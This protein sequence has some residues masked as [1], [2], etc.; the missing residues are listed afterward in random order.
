[1]DSELAKRLNALNEQNDA[2]REAEGE[3]LA[4]KGEKDSLLAMLTTKAEGKSHSERETIA[5][6]SDDWRKF[7]KALSL[8]ETDYQYQR[9]R[10][11]ILEKAYLAEH[12]SFTAEAKL[13]K[14]QGIMT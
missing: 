7:N 8:I 6:A 13:I 12:A 9:R 5:L 14:R 4:L 2:L 11:A 1:M 10:F 3:F